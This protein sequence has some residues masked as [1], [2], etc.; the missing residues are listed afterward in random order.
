MGTE[1]K[2]HEEEFTHVSCPDWE[3]LYGPTDT[4]L[5][6]GEGGHIGLGD[7]ILSLSKHVSVTREEVLEDVENLPFRHADLKGRV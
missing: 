3:G 2:T 1:V 7:V 5:I 6:E 4:L